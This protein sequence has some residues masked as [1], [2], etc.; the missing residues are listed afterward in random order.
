MTYWSL[1]L[2]IWILL[3]SIIS[4]LLISDIHQQMQTLPTHT[5]VPL[6]VEFARMDLSLFDKVACDWCSIINGTCIYSVNTIIAELQQGGVDKIMAL[7]LGRVRCLVWIA[8]TILENCPRTAS[9]LYRWDCKETVEDS[10]MYQRV[11]RAVLDTGVVNTSG[12]MNQVYPLVAYAYF[13]EAQERRWCPFKQIKECGRAHLAYDS[14][15]DSEVQRVR[16]ILRANGH[17]PCGT[18]VSLINGDESPR[19][20]QNHIA[21]FI[22]TWWHNMLSS[23]KRA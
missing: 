21:T 2:E 16:E 5:V 6:P 12:V 1:L 7:K 4:C 19:P 14:R 13:A 3:P 20:S 8:R 17:V 18:C 10:I 11:L 15:H 23:N 22:E 9:Y